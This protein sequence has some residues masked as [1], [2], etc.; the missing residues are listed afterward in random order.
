MFSKQLSPLIIPLLKD[1]PGVIHMDMCRTHPPFGSNALPNGVVCI[2]PP[3]IPCEHP[4]LNIKNRLLYSCLWFPLI[5]QTTLWRHWAKSFSAVVAVSE[6]L[7]KRLVS[8]GMRNV[9]VIPNGVPMH[10]ERPP[11]SHPPTV[12]FAGRLVPEKGGDVLIR[13]FAKIVS[14][15]P[16]ARLLIAGEGPDR[17]RL[18]KL[19]EKLGVSTSVSFLGWLS[20]DKLEQVLGTSW[21]QAIPSIWEDPHPLTCLEAVMRGTAVVGSNCGGIPEIIQDGR[22]GVLVTPG[23]VDAWTKAL[24]EILKD[25][26][27]AEKIGKAARQDALERFSE[28]VY[29]DQFEKLFKKMTAG[30]LEK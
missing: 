28:E 22:T 17:P 29:V 16:Q 15:I 25:P 9:Q 5:L 1:W 19:T 6:S 13:A 11:L 14:V 2:V 18:E 26:V 21:V 20:Q 4:H 30:E 8:L 24:Q 12:A 3:A 27:A 10:S 23:D 7:K